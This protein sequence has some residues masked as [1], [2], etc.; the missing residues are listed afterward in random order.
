MLR[1]FSR[2]HLFHVGQDHPWGGDRRAGH[3]VASGHLSFVSRPVVL[4]ADVAGRFVEQHKLPGA[5]EHDAN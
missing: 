3:S 4:S 1:G 2:Y 5:S